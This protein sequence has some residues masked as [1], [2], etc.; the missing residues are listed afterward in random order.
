MDA[1]RRERFLRR[2]RAAVDAAHRL[3]GQSRYNAAVSLANQGRHEEARP[4]A[5]QAAG[6]PEWQER[7]RALTGTGTP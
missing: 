6:W 4:W 5:E 7:A 3:E 1:G 2:A